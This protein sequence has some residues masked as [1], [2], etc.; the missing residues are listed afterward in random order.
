MPALFVCPFHML[1][2]RGSRDEEGAAIVMASVTYTVHRLLLALGLLG[3]AVA[4]CQ[5][6]AALDPSRRWRNH[7]IGFFLVFRQLCLLLAYL[8]LLTVFRRTR[9]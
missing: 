4:L 7:P 2:P 6:Q 8:S 1:S 3:A 5:A 9:V